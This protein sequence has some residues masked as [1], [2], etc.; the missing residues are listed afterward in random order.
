MKMRVLLFVTSVCFAVAQAPAP[1]AKK[2]VAQSPQPST[3]VAAPSE[4]SPLTEDDLLTIKPTL[5]QPKLVRDPFSAPTDVANQK[6]GDLIDDIGV[7][8]R[9]V[10][11]GKVMAVVSDSRGNVRWLAAGYKFRDGE[12]FEITE[13][14]VIFHQRDINSTSG[15]FRTVVR[16]FKRE[17]GK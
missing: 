3:A 4:G 5:Y 16:S 12:L 10:S 17:E 15:V 7:K 8:G 14:A 6:G 2:S 11:N 1:S 13:K 9:I